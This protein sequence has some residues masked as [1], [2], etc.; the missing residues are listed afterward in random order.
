[1]ESQIS[2]RNNHVAFQHPETTVSQSNDTVIESFSPSLFLRQCI[3]ALQGISDSENF[4]F[5]EYRFH[6]YHQLHANQLHPLTFEGVLCNT[7]A[8]AQLMMDAAGSS[9]SALSMD[10]KSPDALMICGVVGVYVRC[11][12]R[13]VHRHSSEITS[14]ILRAF[15]CALQE[16]LQVYFSFLAG[17]ASHTCTDPSAQSIE[18]TVAEVFYRIDPF[19]LRLKVLSL[20]VSMVPTTNTEQ[21]GI[22]LL[23]HLYRHLLHHG[24]RSMH[25]PLLYTILQ[26]TI[27]PWFEMLYDWTVDGVLSDVFPAATDAMASEFF[28]RAHPHV[29]DRALWRDG[30][31][32]RYDYVPLGI[33]S[34][35]GATDSATIIDLIFM[36]GKGVN[37]IR[38][39]LH[40]TDWALLPHLLASIQMVDV[41][42]VTSFGNGQLTSKKAC[43][44]MLGFS[45]ESVGE[46]TYRFNA[47]DTLSCGSLLRRT[48]KL[49]SS[50]VHTHILSCLRTDFCLEE[51]LYAM[52]QF[53]LFGQ[54]D[55]YSTLMDGLHMEFDHR[56]STVNAGIIGIFRH[57]LTNIVDSCIKST[58][59]TNFSSTTL[60]RVQV[61][62]LLDENDDAN[63]LFALPRETGKQSVGNVPADERTVWDIFSLTYTVP[64]PVVS[65]V[66]AGAMMLYQTV[67]LFL[68]R[69]N[70]IDFRLN[71]T[72]RQNS[73][74]QHALHTNAQHLGITV[75]SNLAY[76]QAILLLR[77]IA[78]TRQ[79][80]V[81][82]VTNLKSYLMYEV[83]D[84]CWKRFIPVMTSSKTLD[85]IIQAH[86]R[87]IQE[88]VVS[89]FLKSSSQSVSDDF[90]LPGI[91][92]VLLEFV[93]GFCSYQESLFGEALD[94]ANRAAQ[95]RSTAEL[96]AKQGS[97]GFHRER[98]AAEQ[99]TCFGLSDSSKLQNLD[100]FSEGFN[101]H[102]LLFLEALDH[103]LNG[104]SELRNARQGINETPR[105]SLPKCIQD[106]ND[107]SNQVDLDSLRYL[108]SQ[109]NHNNFY[110]VTNF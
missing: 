60:E 14:S 39:C 102:M 63:F 46:N 64:D 96:L 62:L 44:E 51:H 73:A 40:D 85:E 36:I 65:V 94:S 101:K 41:P 34:T 53:L 49:A 7:S 83:I 109:F 43:M 52:K 3:Y 104:Y 67:F 21:A 19:V 26:S 59:A 93:K 48:L 50:L 70:H 90:D 80:M 13:F 106:D 107:F 29:S 55:F 47:S 75:H 56:Y 2:F 98:E 69:V 33:F 99:E 1:M 25:V 78:V 8:W 42:N 37:Y 82:F 38:R 77:Q 79:A 24:N 31:I 92:E 61:Q 88:I 108:A 9:T 35:D 72:W 28:I 68:F 97:W 22:H 6:H 58:N 76:Q 87:Y 45:Y 91:L 100:N 16:D 81:H 54:G 23:S 89:S 71:R 95:K 105:A 103:K 32:V 15:R 110:G 30:Y 12:Q 57:S 5:Y 10:T 17:L 20:I 66:D 27:Q 4:L 84:C 11:I 18:L 86:N 74:L